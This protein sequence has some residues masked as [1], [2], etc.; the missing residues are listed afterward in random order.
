MKAPVVLATKKDADATVND[1]ACFF[2]KLPQ[3]V[4]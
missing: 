2:I 4:P 3:T 1:K